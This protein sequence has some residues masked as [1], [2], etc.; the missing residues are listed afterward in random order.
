M[1]T[2][3]RDRLVPNIHIFYSR[4]FHRRPEI[5]PPRRSGHPPLG[6]E[7][8]VEKVESCATASS[9]VQGGESVATPAPCMTEGVGGER[10]SCAPPK[11]DT[12]V[13]RSRW[14]WVAVASAA[15]AADWRLITREN[16]SPPPTTSCTRYLCTVRSVQCGLWH[17]RRRRNNQIVDICGLCRKLTEPSSP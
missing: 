8:C 16:R 13:P 4:I 14:S 7:T 6:G 9:V 17:S 12:W 15:S 3:R 11:G 10:C 2:A 5:P 1:R